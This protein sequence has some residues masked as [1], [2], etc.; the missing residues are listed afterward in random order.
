MIATAN[1]RAAQWY[2]ADKQT[3]TNLKGEIQCRLVGGR[4][5]H[6]VEWSIRAVVDDLRHGWVEEQGEVNT[7]E[8][9]DDERV[10][11]NLTQHEGPVG[12]EDLID[13]RTE[14]TGAGN[15]RRCSVPPLL[16]G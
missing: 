13:L 6:A 1:R 4:H 14:Q 11:R 7:R 15:A 10:Q 16:H 8:D 2:L 3:T 12:R 5:F 9:E